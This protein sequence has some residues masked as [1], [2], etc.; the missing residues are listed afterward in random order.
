[1]LSQGSIWRRQVDPPRHAEVG[2]PDELRFGRII[3]DIGEEELTVTMQSVQ[4]PALQAA[5]E[6][7][8]ILL[9]AHHAQ[10]GNDDP[11][12]APPLDVCQQRPPR[13]FD[14]GKLGHG[15][16]VE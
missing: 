7:G 11:L 4:D 3:P 1:M 12:D 10:P 9:A 2:N 6:V 15:S 8:R 16:G 5:G 14:F 13:A